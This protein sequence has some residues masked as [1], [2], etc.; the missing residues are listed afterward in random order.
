MLVF[1]RSYNLVAAND[2]D[3]TNEIKLDKLRHFG[4]GARFSYTPAKARLQFLQT[5][6]HS[7]KETAGSRASQRR[8]ALPPRTELTPER[9]PDQPVFRA[10]ALD[11][12]REKAAGARV[13]GFA[14]I[15]RCSGVQPRAWRSSL[16]RRWSW[17][18]TWTEILSSKRSNFLARPVSALCVA[19]TSLRTS[20]ASPSAP[21]TPAT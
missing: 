17:S 15:K 12:L 21:A 18:L 5:L 6:K 8:R 9:W 11:S 1:C 16:R 2:R 7:G 14:R 3:A 10:Y 13:N 4:V 20:D 19:L